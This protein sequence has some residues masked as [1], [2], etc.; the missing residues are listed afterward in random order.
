[1]FVVQE[2]DL[3]T[4]DQTSHVGTMPTWLASCFLM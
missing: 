4:V 1:M 3:V 2:E